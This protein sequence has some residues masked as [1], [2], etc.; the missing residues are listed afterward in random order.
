MHI[1]YHIC[2]PK[3]TVQYVGLLQRQF[4]VCSLCSP[5]PWFNGVSVFNSGYRWS[6]IDS[7]SAIHGQP[8]CKRIGGF[9]AVTHTATISIS[10]PPPNTHTQTHAEH[11]S[12]HKTDRAS[13]LHTPKP[14][15][16]F[17]SWKTCGRAKGWRTFYLVL[18]LSMLYLGSFHPP[19]DSRV[20][21]PPRRN[22]TLSL[23]KSRYLT[24]KSGRHIRQESFVNAHHF[25]AAT[26][27]W[28]VTAGFI[29]HI[30]YVGWEGT[31][32]RSDIGPLW[33]DVLQWDNRTFKQE[34]GLLSPQ[35]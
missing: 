18:L 16:Q 4:I 6:F 9:Q 29:H 1:Y 27:S 13:L 19:A 3:C 32:G 25:G 28:N 15:M 35:N 5:D 7:F 23:P 33:E 21:T 17:I 11:L 8:S 14:D 12:T 22:L 34:N 26:W 31:A 30:V 24:G 10:T 2:Q 20:Y